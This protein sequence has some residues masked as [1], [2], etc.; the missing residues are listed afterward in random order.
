MI[1]ERGGAAL[2]K[3]AV[4]GAA[5]AAAALLVRRLLKTPEVKIT[6]VRGEVPAEQRAANE[7]VEVP[8][9]AQV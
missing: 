9:G 3:L 7:N 4:G 5:I 6:V 2:L 8:W 1:I